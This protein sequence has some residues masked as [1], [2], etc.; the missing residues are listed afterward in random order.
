MPIIEELNERRGAFPAVD[1]LARDMAR[2]ARAEQTKHEAVCTER[3]R[4]LEEA[5]IALVKAIDSL[6]TAITKRFENGST[7]MRRIEWMI[8]FLG[9]VIIL[10]AVVG[11]NKVIDTAAASITNKI[12]GA[13]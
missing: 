3:Y 5:N 6:G 11:D 13:R 7:R 8:L 10:A 9:A 4:R 12:M 2:D 1:Q